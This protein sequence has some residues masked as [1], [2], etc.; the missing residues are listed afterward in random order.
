MNKRGLV[1]ELLGCV[2]AFVVLAGLLAVAAQAQTETPKPGSELKKL[3]M[4]IGNWS[5]EGVTTD[6]RQ[7]TKE[8]FAGRTVTHFVLGGVFVED[9]WEEKSPAGFTSGIQIYGYDAQAKSYFVNGYSCD[10]GSYTGSVT[11]EGD[12]LTNSWTQTSGKGE[13]SLVKGVWKYSP[14]RNSFTSS[15]Q[16]SRDEGKTWTPWVEYK[17]VKLK[18]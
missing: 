4:M 11:I 5:Y 7:G 15:W 2:A 1:L 3:E 18:K 16:L 17:A 12:I 6:A 10:G 14:D 8:K 13:K 9:K